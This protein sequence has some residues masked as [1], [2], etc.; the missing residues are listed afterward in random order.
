MAADDEAATGNNQPHPFDVADG[1]RAARKAKREGRP[2]DPNPGEPSEL[3]EW[4]AG[5][6]PGPIPPRPWILGDQ[7][8]LGFISSIV[9]AGG[10]GKSA[11]RLLQYISLALGRS[12]C[13]QHVFRRCRVL[14][15]SL[16]DDRNELQRRIKAVLI[17][18]NIARSELKS[19]L[20]CATPKLSKLAQMNG[21]IRKDQYRALLGS[22][23]G[24][25]RCIPAGDH[26]GTLK[27]DL[28]RLLCGD[29][30]QR[31]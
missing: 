4:D 8:C 13:C 5:D 11:L 25:S 20:Y 26:T 22:G 6:D 1:A 15:I 12:L 31:A 10:A 24:S 28:E 9:A 17:H 7:F 23:C 18:Y 16:E 3:G 27:P 21:K 19:W 30:T 2:Q 29:Q 14:L